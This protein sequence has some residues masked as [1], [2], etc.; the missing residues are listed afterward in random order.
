[1]K[2]NDQYLSYAADCQLM[3]CRTRDEHERKTWLEMAQSWLQLVQLPT[4]QSFFPFERDQ[5]GKAA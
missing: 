2:M 5:F 4:R 3:A 1:M